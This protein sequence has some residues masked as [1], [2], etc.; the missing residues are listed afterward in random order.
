MRCEICQ[1][2]FLSRRRDAK[3]CSDPCRVEHNRRRAAVRG[4]TH[5]YERQWRDI[6]P[7]TRRQREMMMEGLHRLL[8][9]PADEVS[10]VFGQAQ[11]LGRPMSYRETE[12]H[13]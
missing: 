10:L 6:P 2:E 1:R 13:L 11:S 8:L 9:T 5:P 12:V 4:K 7:P 3:V